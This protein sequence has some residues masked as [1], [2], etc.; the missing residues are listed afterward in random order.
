MNDYVRE[1]VA[2]ARRFQSSKT[3]PYQIDLVRRLADALEG[4]PSGPVADS[5]RETV[6]DADGEELFI[7]RRSVGFAYFGGLSGDVANVAVTSEAWRGMGSPE[8][9]RVSVAPSAPGSA[10]ERHDVE[11]RS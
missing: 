5:P 10:G 8:A 7:E 6:T 9:V 4:R 1:L 2:E 3:W 11:A